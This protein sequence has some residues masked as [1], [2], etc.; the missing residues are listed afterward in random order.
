MA[1]PTLAPGLK[2]PLL[3]MLWSISG[4]K[5]VPPSPALRRAHLGWYEAKLE[6]RLRPELNFGRGKII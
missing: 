5:L 1:S 3:E 2:M 6:E 4:D